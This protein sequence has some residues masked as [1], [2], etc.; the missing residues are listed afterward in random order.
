MRR[1]EVLVAV[2]AA[3]STRNDGEAVSLLHSHYRFAPAAPT[4][5]NAGPLQSTRVFIRDGF[6]DRY[7]GDRPSSTP[8]DLA[9]STGRLP[10]SPELED[11]GDSLRVL[12]GWSYRRPLRP[13]LS[14]WQF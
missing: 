1:E 13:A 12:G 8:V 11:H 14:R 6:I 9:C 10:V 3:L 5:H 7:S 4:K 2:C